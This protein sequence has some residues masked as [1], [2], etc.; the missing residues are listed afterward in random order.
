MLRLKHKREE[1][2]ARMLA[3]KAGTKPNSQKQCKS[4]MHVHMMEVMVLKLHAKWGNNMQIIQ[5]LHAQANR[6]LK[7]TFKA[8]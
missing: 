4:E 6:G 8:I 1:K 5:I 7:T 3:T 2:H